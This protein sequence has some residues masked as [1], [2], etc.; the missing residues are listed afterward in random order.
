MPQRIEYAESCKLNTNQDSVED[1]E[2]CPNLEQVQNIADFESQ[3]PP[4]PL[5]QMAKHPRTIVLLSDYI[6]ERLECDAQGCLE[7][8]LQNTPYYTFAT[9][10]ENKYNQCGIKKMAMKRYNDNVLKVPN[11][12]LHIPSFKYR[13]VVQNIVA[14]MTDDQA[15][16]ERKLHTLE[17]MRGNDNHQYPI[18][19][20]SRDCMK[21][22]RWLISQSAYTE[23]LI[24]SPQHCFNRN[25]P[26]KSLY[27]T[28]HT[29]Y[30]WWETQVSRDIQ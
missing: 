18:K 23:R 9:C 24:Y 3:P 26:L 5:P 16:R 14:S 29:A 27:T 17:D 28:L 10:K 30:W 19:L 1:F 12:A 22:M 7:I 4:S 15:F 21:C 11:T 13:D 6:A 20:W 25:S 2:A 8:N